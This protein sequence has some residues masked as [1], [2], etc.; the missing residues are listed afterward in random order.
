MENNNLTISSDKISI[1]EWILHQNPW[2]IPGLLVL[3]AFSVFKIAFGREIGSVFSLVLGILRNR[4]EKADKKRKTEDWIADCRKREGWKQKADAKSID[5]EGR[6]LKKLSFRVNLKESPQNWRAG[7]ILGNEKFKPQDIIDT[8]NAITIHIG[9]PPILKDGIH[10]WRYDK[11]HPVNH[12]EEAPV[13]I[14]KEYNFDIE[15]TP[16][17]SLKVHIGKQIVYSKRIDSSFRQ[18]LYLL[19][20]A[21]DSSDCRIN[22]ENI[23]FAI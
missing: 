11:D 16:N 2:F 6:Y 20:W 18:K 7:F 13:L 23:K 15:I 10:V 9:Y 8:V 14:S 21:D 3:I 19:A 1:P 12:G 5:L 17:N 4:F 22:F